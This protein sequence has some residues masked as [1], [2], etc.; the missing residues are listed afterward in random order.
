MADV[1]TDLAEVLWEWDGSASF[2][3]EDYRDKAE[4]IIAQLDQA[5]YKVISKK[6]NTGRRVMVVL[7]MG[8]LL[9]ALWRHVTTQPTS[10]SATTKVLNV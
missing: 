5:G 2:V 8:L 4:T 10:T 7:V 3:S 9:A 6:R 1:I